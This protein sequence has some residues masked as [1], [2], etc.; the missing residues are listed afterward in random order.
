[1]AAIE[2]RAARP[3]NG[4]AE[5]LADMVEVVKTGDEWL[6]Y[7]TPDPARGNPL[8]LKRLADE[9]VPVVTLSEVARSLEEVYLQV[10][11]EE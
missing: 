5:N 4:L 3:L 8:L 10:V 1:M 2:L 9:G 7:R 6:R 11:A